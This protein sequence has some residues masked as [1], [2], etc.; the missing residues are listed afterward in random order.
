MCFEI[1]KKN[2]Q[3]NLCVYVC[4]WLPGLPSLAIIRFRH[5][6][7][8]VAGGLGWVEVRARISQT[9]Q[10][11]N[12]QKNKLMCVLSFTNQEYKTNHMFMCVRGF[13]GLQTF[14]FVWFW[15]PKG[16]GWGECVEC[17]GAQDFACLSL[18][19]ITLWRLPPPLVYIPYSTLIQN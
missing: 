13:Q 2:R 16:K 5:C 6:V 14:I 18:Y 9:L 17:G 12:M 11:P 15:H 4:L 19:E 8:G 1:F 10:N 3:T 7:G